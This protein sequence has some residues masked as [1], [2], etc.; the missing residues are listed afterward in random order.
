M[1]ALS[2]VNA[3]TVIT[4]TIYMPYAICHTLIPF[5]ICHMYTYYLTLFT[6]NFVECPY[7]EYRIY[8]VYRISNIEYRIPYIEYHVACR[9]Q[10]YV[11]CTMLLCSYAA[12]LLCCYAAMH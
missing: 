4:A 3:L 7:N 8:T 9:V 2:M 6:I 11:I 12:M 10:G 1:L 5:T